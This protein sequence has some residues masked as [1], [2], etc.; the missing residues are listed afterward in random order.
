MAFAT[1]NFNR[2]DGG[3]GSNWTALQ[4]SGG[5]ANGHAIVSN[6]AA[7]AAAGYCFSV[8]NANDFNDDQYSQYKE[9]NTTAYSGVGTRMPASGQVDGYLWTN[10]FGSDSRLYRGDDGIFTLVASGWSIPAAGSI[11]KQTSTGSNH[12]VF[13]DGASLGSGTDGTYGT[14]NPGIWSLDTTAKLDDWE[15]GDLAS[16]PPDSVFP[17]SRRSLHHYRRDV[18]RRRAV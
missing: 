17:L 4:N 7:A 2:A 12:E 9:V 8:W 18:F 5:V 14:G 13:D 10:N 3:V 16:V 1:D 6:E 11:I 15:G